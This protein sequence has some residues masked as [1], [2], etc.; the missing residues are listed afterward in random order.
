MLRRDTLSVSTLGGCHGDDLVER[1]HGGR[2]RSEADSRQFAAER[3]THP[4]IIPPNRT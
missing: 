2:H 3:S 4:Q 1:T